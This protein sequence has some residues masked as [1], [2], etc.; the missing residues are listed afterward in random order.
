MVILNNQKLTQMLHLKKKNAFVIH[1][2]A[3]KAVIPVEIK[4]IILIKL[5]LFQNIIHGIKDTS[6]K[7]IGI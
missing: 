4:K 1:T 2:C 6:V 5:G 7:T 3:K